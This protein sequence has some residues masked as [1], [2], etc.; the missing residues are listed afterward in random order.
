MP[1]RED[2]REATIREERLQDEIR[3]AGGSPFCPYCSSRKVYYNPHFGSWRCG[4]C[5]KS[6]RRPR[7]RLNGDSGEFEQ[8]ESGG[9]LLQ[10]FLSI[11]NRLFT[12]LR[13]AIG[14]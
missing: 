2:E 5:E 12:S 7:Y 6:F 13:K 10:E 11:I 9:T 3:E 14:K 8:E 4:S 1:R